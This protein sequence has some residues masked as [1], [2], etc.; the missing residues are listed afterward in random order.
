MDEIIINFFKKSEWGQ[1]GGIGHI[2][3]ITIELICAAVFAGLIGWEREYRGHA[4]GLRTHILVSLGACL[5]MIISVSAPAFNGV[6]TRDP[7]R[8]AAQVVSGIGFLG[9]G[10]IIQ[11]GTDIKGLTTAATIWLC[12]AIGLAAG[13]GYFSGAI[14]AT[15]VS[16]ITLILLTKIEVKINKRL[17]RI[18]LLLQ[19]ETPVLKD[20]V[21]LSNAYDIEVRNI[22]SNIVK[23]KKGNQMYHLTIL[24]NPNSNSKIESFGEEL[25][26]RL[27]PID[28]KIYHR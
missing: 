26:Y 10:T 28:Y 14:I 9:A 7:A 27:N 5:I 16:L 15:A 6:T 25:K 22:H 19:S 8:L 24:L 2:I 23:D 20:I 13:S 12:G 11:T 4:A 1:F 3:L 18:I 17:P 21:E